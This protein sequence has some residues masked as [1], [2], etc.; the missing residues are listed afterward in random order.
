MNFSKVIVLVLL[1]DISLDRRAQM[2]KIIIPLLFLAAALWAEAK[3]ELI[4]H[5]IFPEEV[6][7]NEWK[8]TDSEKCTDFF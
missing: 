5:I 6:Y 7:L 3:I 2:K 1:C 4:V 8:I